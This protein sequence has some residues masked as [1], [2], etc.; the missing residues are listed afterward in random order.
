MATPGQCPK[1]IVPL[2]NCM[3]DLNGVTDGSITLVETPHH[4]QQIIDAA[5][6]SLFIRDPGAFPVC[7]ILKLNDAQVQ[8]S[9][10]ARQLV[11][12]A[13]LLLRLAAPGNVYYNFI[14][15]DPCGWFEN[16]SQA[17]AAS[18]QTSSVFFFKGWAHPGLEE[19]MVLSKEQAPAALAYVVANSE[20]TV[21]RKRAFTSFFRGYHE[22]YA[23][24]RLLRNAIG[25]ENLF[26]NDVGEQSNVIYK[27]VDRGAYLLQ[28]AAPLPDGAEGYVVPL[29]NIYKARS[30]L[31]HTNDKELNWDKGDVVELLV[32]SDR[33]LRTALRQVLKDTLLLDSTEIDKRKRARYR[34]DEAA[35]S[36]I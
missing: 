36:T 15:H 14:L 10:L 1:A 24:D 19:G 29:K 7:L 18:L 27:F 35:P 11:E 8:D 31:V 25:L 33:Y 28:L 9:K 32:N 26:V 6:Q 17:N 2:G 3:I 13:I 4:V 5:R 16:P 34:S 30:R 23:D 20:K 21:I 12:D 22:P